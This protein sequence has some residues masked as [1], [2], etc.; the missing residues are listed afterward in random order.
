[1]SIVIIQMKVHKEYK[2]GKKLIKGLV[3]DGKILN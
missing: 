2:I 1:M 3:F